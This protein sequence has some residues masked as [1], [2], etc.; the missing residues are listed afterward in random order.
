MKYAYL[1]FMICHTQLNICPGG[2]ED[3]VTQGD[4]HPHLESPKR[5]VHLTIDTDDL[6]IPHHLD[7]TSPTGHRILLAALRIL[8]A[9]QDVEPYD[10]GLPTHPHLEIT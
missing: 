8:L 7:I 6:D 9:E 2:G 1:S 4:G 5:H 10:I 3:N